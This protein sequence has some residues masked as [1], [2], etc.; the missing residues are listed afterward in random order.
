MN[1][2]LVVGG[3]LLALLVP[4]ALAGSQRTQAR[5]S[6]SSFEATRIRASMSSVVP[7][8]DVHA[9]RTG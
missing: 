2:A 9:G 1:K 5:S 8:A 3:L 7:E 6:V 4:S